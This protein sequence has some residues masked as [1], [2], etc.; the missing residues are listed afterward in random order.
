MKKNGFTLV[1]ILVAITVGLIVMAA[2]YGAM[3]MAQRTSAGLGRKVVT[4]QDTRAVLDFMASEIRMASYNPTMVLTTWNNWDATRV[5]A[6]LTPLDSTAPQQTR[7]GIQI[8]TANRIAIAMDLDASGKIGNV[9]NEFIIYSYDTATG[10]I[11]R[12]V[13]CGGDNDIL[14]GTALGTNV[15][16]ASLPTPIAVFQYFDRTGTPLT[17]VPVNIPDIRRIKITIAAE[18]A[19]PDLNTKERKRMIYSTDILVRNHA[20][21]TPGF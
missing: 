15:L 14:G 6:C 17:A 18:T 1:E 8:A 11:T 12:N 4:Q 13:S 9:A 7:K 16:N 19:D 20:V 5:L 2:I 3:V 10:A 21:F